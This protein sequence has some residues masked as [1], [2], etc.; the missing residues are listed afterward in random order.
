MNAEG[1]SAEPSPSAAVRKLGRAPRSP[2]NATAASAAG[3]SLGPAS[4]PAAAPDPTVALM[5]AAAAAAA[6]GPQAL[7]EFVRLQEAVRD[8]VS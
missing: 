2:A 8:D 3:P 5:A 1:P 6:R 7:I 4:A